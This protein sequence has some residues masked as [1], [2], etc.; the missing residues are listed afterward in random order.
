MKN[1]EKKRK[2]KR[3]KITGAVGAVAGAI[4]GAASSGAVAS[5]LG[6]NSIPVLTAL[7][8]IAGITI[9]GPTP[10]GLTIGLAVGGAAIGAGL[11]KMIFHSGRAEQFE[12]D[13]DNLFN[14][15]KGEDK[16]NKDEDDNGPTSAGV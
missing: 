11:A 4:A 3:N 10:I 16:N 14:K 2:S 12:K 9:V 13:L 6:V 8:G 15:N 5:A 7:G 1:E